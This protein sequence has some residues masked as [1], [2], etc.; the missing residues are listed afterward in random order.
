MIRPEQP[1]DAAAIREV[2][3]AAFRGHGEQVAE[4]AERIR[5]S[6]NAVPELALV[7][8]DESGVVA[9]VMLS[10]VGL[11]GGPRDRVLVLTPMSVRPDRQRQGIGRAL[12]EEVL[13][14]AD[15]TGEPVVLVEGI[16]AYY[17]RFGFEPA[18]ELG[19]EKPNASIPDEAFMARKL[20][21]YDPSV[22]G[23]VV[24]PAAYDALTSP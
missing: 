20:S 22:R 11:V 4:F 19:F 13:R 17:P 7:T 24:Y 8:V 16:P 2:I 1:G 5:A 3:R 21:G 14:R 12:V 10:Y 15:A 18:R 9:H 23:S 6:E